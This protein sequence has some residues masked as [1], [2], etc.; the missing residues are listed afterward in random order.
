MKWKLKIEIYFFLIFNSPLDGESFISAWKKNG[1]AEIK[2][3]QSPEV[4]ELDTLKKGVLEGMNFTL[5]EG[6]EKD[7]NNFSVSG[8]LVTNAKG[9]NDQNITIPCLLRFETKPGTKFVR[10]TVRSGHRGVSTGLVQ[11]ASVL[12]GASSF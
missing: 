5:I 8:N 11:N 9:P 3:I 1:N 6:V 12:L 7:D 4:V 10:V 2:V